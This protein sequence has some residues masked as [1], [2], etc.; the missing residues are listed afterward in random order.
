MSRTPFSNVNNIHVHSMIPEDQKNMTTQWC[1]T[2]RL[3]TAATQALNTSIRLSVLKALENPLK[4][5]SSLP[6]I[7]TT[8]KPAQ[9]D[10]LLQH[11]IMKSI[12]TRH[13]SLVVPL[14]V[15][16]CICIFTVTDSNCD[17]IILFQEIIFNYKVLFM[18]RNEKENVICV[19]SPA[20]M[21]IYLLKTK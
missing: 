13:G 18:E 8:R 1:S 21:V 17:S 11:N 16:I 9:L 15:V 10:A 7:E 5:V 14:W 4:L 20:Y 3:F 12:L 6:G 2:G 19:F